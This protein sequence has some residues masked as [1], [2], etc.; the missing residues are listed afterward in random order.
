[1]GSRFFDDDLIPYFSTSFVSLLHRFR[2]LLIYQ[3]VGLHN[4][5][6]FA[7]GDDD[8]INVFE[9]DFI[10]SKYEERV[11][12]LQECFIEAVLIFNESNLRN[13]GAFAINR[14]MLSILKA[15]LDQHFDALLA[16]APDALLWML[17]LGMTT[18]QWYS[19]APSGWFS[20]QMTRVAHMLGTRSW[21]QMKAFLQGYFFIDR[22]PD[23]IENNFEVT[24]QTTTKDNHWVD[25]FP[26]EM[27]CE[28]DSL[29]P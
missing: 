4:P 11:S 29:L 20:T 19:A 2:G 1:M 9:H 6:I 18:S 12:P 14:R 7:E 16:I 23:G 25:V 8:M 17:H 13:C 27:S 3:E 15:L 21:L 5:E 10:E 22:R 28:K 26:S 24:W